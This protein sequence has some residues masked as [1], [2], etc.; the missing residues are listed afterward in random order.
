MFSATKLVVAGAIVALIGGSVLTGVLT[1]QSSD[2]RAPVVGLSASAATQAE[3]SASAR[4]QLSSEA[5]SDG[6][7]TTADLLPGVDLVTEAVAPGIYR[8]LSDGFNDLTRH[9]WDVAVTPGGEVWVVKQRVSYASTNRPSRLKTRIRDARVLRLGDEKPSYKPP[10]RANSPSL[11]LDIYDGRPFVSVSG[12]K[13]ERGWT[14][15]SWVRE[16][17]NRPYLGLDAGRWA[18]YR[19]ARGADGTVWFSHPDGRVTHRLQL[20]DS[21]ATGDLRIGPH[22]SGPDGSLWVVLVDMKEPDELG[23][24]ARPSLCEGAP[25]LHFITPEALA[26]VEYPPLLSD[27]L[28][29]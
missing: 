28:I 17:R 27:A 14:G 1:E 18:G 8:V 7:R 26:E 16:K 24:A 20:P 9:V 6:R 15:K 11:S 19:F 25:G 5:E 21:A 3:S 13:L 12:L 2:D 29:P 22:A 4:P 10:E 23:C